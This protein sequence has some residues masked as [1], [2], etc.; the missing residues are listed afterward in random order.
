MTATAILLLS[1][2]CL[3]WSNGAN[4]NFKG[5]AALYGSG[6]V[7]FRQ[8]LR[9]ATAATLL[10]SAVSVYLADLLVKQFSGVGIIP[11]D[12]INGMWLT[13]VGMS[14]ALTILLATVLGMPTSTTHALIG[15]LGAGIYWIL[16]LAQV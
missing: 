15:A 12:Q 11:T 14:G 13:A 2:F 3:A 16:R 7:T 5:V 6:T 8:A 9:W 10:G 4:D 1:V